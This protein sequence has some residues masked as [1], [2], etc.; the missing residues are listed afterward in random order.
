MNGHYRRL[1]PIAERFSE[2]LLSPAGP[3]LHASLQDPALVL[4]SQ[5]ASGVI[6]TIAED[7]FCGSSSR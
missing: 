5:V 3:G 7:E 4:R 1:S 6:T 2:G